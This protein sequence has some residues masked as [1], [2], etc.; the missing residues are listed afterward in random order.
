MVISD[1]RA[2]DTVVDARCR[3]QRLEAENEDEVRARKGQG[4][5]WRRFLPT[6]ARF[7]HCWRDRDRSFGAAFMTPDCYFVSRA[8]PASAAFDVLDDVSRGRGQQRIDGR[9]SPVLSWP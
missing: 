6:I 3:E 2:R 5:A 1:A 7:L 9:R 4:A 8:F